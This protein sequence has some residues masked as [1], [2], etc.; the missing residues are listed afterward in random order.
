MFQNW[1]KIN[2]CIKI[3]TTSLK[4]GP[5]GSLGGVWGSNWALLGGGGGGSP[6][7]KAEKWS[8][9]M[10]GDA[11][12]ASQSEVLI[13]SKHCFRFLCVFCVF[14]SIVNFDQQ[15]ITFIDFLIRG[16]WFYV[17]LGA[18][19]GTK[20]VRKKRAKKVVF[21]FSSDTL[22]Q[23]WRSES[24]QKRYTF[25]RRKVKIVFWAD[26]YPQLWRSGLSRKQPKSAWK[27]FGKLLQKKTL[28]SLKYGCPR[29]PLLRAIFEKIIE[30]LCLVAKV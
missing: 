18:H 22:G 13:S 6:P 23:I 15:S 29:P 17:D 10:F 28:K 8:K 12:K 30:K 16:T 19:L 4:I 9:G 25:W 27:P 3:D 21:V 26:E 14:Y 11:C 5:W 24:S 20:N 7:K 1:E 2:S